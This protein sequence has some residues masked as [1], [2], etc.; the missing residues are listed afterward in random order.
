VCHFF[1]LE[2]VDR[3]PTLEINLTSHAQK[4]GAAMSGF[5]R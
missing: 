5:F 4:L 3:Q 2:F 1:S